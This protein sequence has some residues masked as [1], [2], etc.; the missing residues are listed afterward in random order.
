LQERFVEKKMIG[1][2]RALSDLTSDAY[3]QDVT[4]L[5]AFRGKGI[6]KKLFKY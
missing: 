5:K 4:V 1:M 3:I 6:G 2:G